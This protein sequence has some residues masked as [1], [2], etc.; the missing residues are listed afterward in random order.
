M[1]N[2]ETIPVGPFQVNCNIIWGDEKE[3]IVIDPGY[4]NAVIADFLKNNHLSVAVYILTHG[5]ADHVH[6]LCLIQEQY[7]APIMM[8]EADADWAFGPSNTI[9]PYYGVPGEPEKI[10]RLLKGNAVY[11]DAG[12]TYQ[13]ICT[14]GHSPGGVCI[15]FEKE[16]KLFAGDT[17]FR[18]SVGRTDLPGGDARTLTES[19]KKLVVLPEETEVY[20][21][22]GPNTTIGYE[23][24]HNFFMNRM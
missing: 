24:D 23:K 3:A 6:D 18:E 22:H 17:L 1:M 8:H 12:L 10:D 14:P 13:V 4:D 9:A 20:C 2:I 21:G 11:T 19:L 16:G 15:Y 5:H 7:P